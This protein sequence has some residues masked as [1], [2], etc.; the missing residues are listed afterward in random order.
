MTPLSKIIERVTQRIEKNPAPSCVGECDTKLA[1]AIPTDLHIQPCPVWK[2]SVLHRL[3][4]RGVPD[5]AARLVVNGLRRTSALER[6]AFFETQELSQGR[7][8]I[9]GGAPGTGKTVAAA[10]IL[11]RNDG[12]M[13]SSS[14]LQK[15]FLDDGE[16]M[17]LRTKRIL[18]LDDL[19]AEHRGDFFMAGF[20][21]L[22]NARYAGNRALIATTNL[23]S[24]DFREIYGARIYSRCREWGSFSQLKG[25]DLRST[26]RKEFDSGKGGA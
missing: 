9:I 10:S 6:V 23:S 5:R 1:G 7:A 8:L 2:E 4:S 25:T 26:Q 22:I 17:K 12:I 3:I 24:P 19:G 20:D 13:V 21:A 11:L 14:D 16:L 18:V 15:R